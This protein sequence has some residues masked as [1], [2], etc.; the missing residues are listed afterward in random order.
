M[1][2]FDQ[3]RLVRVNE[4]WS[5][6]RAQR[7]KHA[8]EPI[9]LT[10]WALAGASHETEP[11]AAVSGRMALVSSLSAIA[12]RVDGSIGQSEGRKPQH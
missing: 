6:C 2:K 10:A 1:E 3:R 7:H 5:R 12:H 11:E 8:I 4:L 9:L